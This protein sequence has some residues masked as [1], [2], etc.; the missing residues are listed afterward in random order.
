MDSLK[1]QLNKMT[2]NIFFGTLNAESRKAALQMLVDYTIENNC[3]KDHKN[4][5][6]ILHPRVYCEDSTYLSVYKII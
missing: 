2:L 4:N 3:K 1:Y 5:K 6:K